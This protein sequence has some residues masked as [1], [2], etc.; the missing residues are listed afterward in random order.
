MGKTENKTAM[1]RSKAPLRISLRPCI[2]CP[3]RVQEPRDLCVKHRNILRSISDPE[4]SASD[5]G[6]AEI[7]REGTLR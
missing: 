2:L 1:R 4:G 5:K 7:M 3:T 6:L